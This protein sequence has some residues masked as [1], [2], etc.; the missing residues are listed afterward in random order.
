MCSWGHA[1]LL[2]SLCPKAVPNKCR[3]FLTALC[4]TWSSVMK[5][6][7]SLQVSNSSATLSW[8]GKTDCSL[9]LY[10]SLLRISRPVTCIRLAKNLDSDWANGWFMFQAVIDCWLMTCLFSNTL[11]SPFNLTCSPNVAKGSGLARSVHLIADTL[12]FSQIRTFG[13]EQQHVWSL[14]DVGSGCSY[15]PWRVQ[16]KYSSISD[17][18]SCTLMP[19]L[20]S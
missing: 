6:T 1:T 20:F 12:L 5:T 2:P 15:H 13:R 17:T 10:S 8:T 18:H 3:L 4:P 9:V 11:L 16:R 14:P 19:F 7:Q